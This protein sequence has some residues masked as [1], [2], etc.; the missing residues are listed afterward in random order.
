M[1]K[2]KSHNISLGENLITL[3]LASSFESLPSGER[4]VVM[5]QARRKRAVRDLSMKVFITFP[6][7]I[8]GRIGN[9]ICDRG[10]R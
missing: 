7:R 5:R 2:K 1:S 8:C 9:W 10:R 6:I 3:G 4:L